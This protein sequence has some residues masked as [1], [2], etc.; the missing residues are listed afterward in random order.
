MHSQ[1]E[2]QYRTYLLLIIP[3]WKRVQLEVFGSPHSQLQA[4]V[5][6]S[7]SFLHLASLNSTDPL[8]NSYLLTRCQ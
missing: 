4:V 6:F 1:N 3:S 2:D 5:L 8:L 7:Y